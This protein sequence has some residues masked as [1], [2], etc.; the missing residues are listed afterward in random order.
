MNQDTKIWALCLLVSILS[1]LLVLSLKSL[2]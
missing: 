2:A 1:A